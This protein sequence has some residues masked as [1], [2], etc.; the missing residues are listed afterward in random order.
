MSQGILLISSILL[1]CFYDQLTHLNCNI[2]FIFFLPPILTLV[3]ERDQL[4]SLFRLLHQSVHLFS[5][6]SWN[7][8]SIFQSL[9]VSA[10]LF[11][12]SL[13]F[14]LS[15][16]IS[17]PLFSYFF[18]PLSFFF[19]LLLLSRG[20]SWQLGRREGVNWIGTYF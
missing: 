16:F 2:P 15:L 8:S 14:L 4:S 3:F 10:H 12:G 1:Q 5:R 18:I 7:S 9:K 11:R 20:M 17:R 6:F 19:V 13:S